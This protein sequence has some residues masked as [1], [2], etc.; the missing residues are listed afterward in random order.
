MSSEVV[1]NRAKPEHWDSMV[2]HTQDQLMAAWNTGVPFA[3]GAASAV[4]QDVEACSTEELDIYAYYGLGLGMRYLSKQLEDTDTKRE[5]TGSLAEQFRTERLT[6]EQLFATE[7]PDASL[8]IRILTAGSQAMLPYATRAFNDLSAA[9]HLTTD[10]LVL[11]TRMRRQKGSVFD[12]NGY[13]KPG[14]IRRAVGGQA[15]AEITSSNS[16]AGSVEILRRATL[17]KR[18]IDPKASG[19]AVVQS[20]LLQRAAQGA[21][22]HTE[23]FASNEFMQRLFP[24]EANGNL[25]YDRAQ[26]PKEPIPPKPGQKQTEIL[27]EA[28]LTCPA[29]QVGRLA[30]IKNVLD[31]VWDA[32][33]RIR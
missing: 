21:M 25:G 16:I 15:S 1:Y 19:E 30:L 23:E 22:L 9:E 2:R 14:L 11:A 3:E 20:Y 12:A 10:A 26:L 17:A 32:G 29:L 24:V 27:H 31:V 5:L 18:S 7:A 28:R 13:V 33:N 4:L 8:N 6:T